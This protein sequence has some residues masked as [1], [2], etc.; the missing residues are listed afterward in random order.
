MYAE[1]LDAMS[2]RAQLWRAL[3]REVGA[4]WRARDTGEGEHGLVR[5]GES[6]DEVSFE[7]PSAA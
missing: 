5:I 7:P 2:E 1:F 3:P 4:W 6:P